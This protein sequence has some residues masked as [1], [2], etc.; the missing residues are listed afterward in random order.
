MDPK[1]RRIVTLEAPTTLTST[2]C[3]E[4]AAALT[5]LAQ[6]RETHSLCNRPG[7][8]ASASALETWIDDARGF[9]SNPA[10][11]TEATSRSG[12]PGKAFVLA[13]IMAHAV[14]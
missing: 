14:Q 13:E 9:C 10:V 8:V 7:D 2:A 11:P 3:Q 6:M 12:Q 4:I 1:A 5:I